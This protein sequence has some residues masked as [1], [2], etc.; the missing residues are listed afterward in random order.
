MNR[1]ILVGGGKLV[2]FL[3]RQFIAKGISVTIISDNRED[4]RYLARQLQATVVFGDG[5]DPQI[6]E[7][8]EATLSDA[9]LAVTPRD[10]DNLVICQIAALQFKVPRVLALVNDPDNEEIFRKL[11][12]TAFST[13]NIIASLIEQKTG[14]D[15]I[16]GLLPMG[17]GKVT[18]AE[19][20]LS[21][22][23]VVC[24]RALREISMPDNSLVAFIL[25]NGTPLV[26]RGSTIILA[27]DRILLVALPE[28]Y[29]AVLR[30]FTGDE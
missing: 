25:R 3:S 14:F 30:T 6:L 10:Q 1:I 8:T 15:E 18:V 7:E 17:G 20:T 5:S 13:T 29:G 24:G 22:K 11:G 9:V 26:P 16:V 2:Y 19:V 28:N 23:S 27:G 4:S 12:V 21:D